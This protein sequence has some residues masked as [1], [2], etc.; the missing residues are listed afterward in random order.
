MGKAVTD[1]K[2]LTCHKEIHSLIDKNK[3]Y[4]SSNDVK[5]KKC[6]NCHNEHH[7]RKFQLIK[8]EEDKFNH[9]KAG[10]ELLGKHFNLKCAECHT[11]KFSKS[12]K[13]KTYLGLNTNCLTCHQDY[14]KGS[15]GQNC[16]SCHNNNTFKEVNKFDHNKARFHLTG[17]HLNVDCAK[18][19]KIEI[20]DGKETQKFKD[21]QFSSCSSCHAD[22]HLGK[23]GTN[24]ES[25]HV[26]NS[27][28][29]IKN[30]GKFDH[31][32]TNFALLGKHLDV[33]C[34]DCHK[35]SISN[36]PKYAKCAD[37]HSDYHE[38]Q[39][40]KNGK[41]RDCSECHIVEGFNNTQYPIEEH[42]KTK[43][44]LLGSHLAIACQ[45]CHYKENKWQFL[46]NGESCVNCH[47][48]IH[49]NIIGKEFFEENKCQSCHNNN[50]WS[51][52]NFD[53]KST[54]FELIGVH[55]KTSCKK[56][57][58]KTGANGNTLQI[59][60][61]LNGNCENCHTDNHAGQFEEEGKTNCIKC[62]TF[63]NWTPEKFLHENTKFK[64]EGAHAKV[65]CDKCHKIIEINNN[66]VKQFKFDDI[67]CSNCHT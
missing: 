27:F 59:F 52:I 18:C 37:C 46:I 51:D 65:T 14:H 24:C 62:H 6:F 13:N 48:N 54:G 16:L 11:Q 4:H 9:K 1:D 30:I 61:E 19:H 22:Q 41:Q 28:K 17:K 2:C 8:F 44:K 53:H 67:K 31:N 60:S 12:K 32:K 15:L 7:G 57:H 20:K 5:S 34:L 39:L 45:S 47:E 40:I 29:E 21:L 23:F 64:L 35:G 66:K 43:F 42:N 25:C 63:I 10:F 3:G 50:A 26:T 55:S 38:G 36:K 58:F 33:T 49:K 56:C